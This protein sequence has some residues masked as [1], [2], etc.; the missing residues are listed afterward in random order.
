VGLLLIGSLLNEYGYNIQLLDCMDRYHPMLRSSS[1]TSIA[2]P[3][4][5]G[6]GRYYKEYIPKPDVLKA[7]PRRFG[8]YGLPLDLVI[9]ELHRYPCPD[10]VFITS[11]MTYWY[12]G[13]VKMI[14]LIR[15]VFPKAPIVL[16]GIY[17]S[18]C[19]D[20]ARGITGAD[21]VVDG[22][23]EIEALKIADELTGNHSE[24]H[25]YKAPED[26]PPPLYE[27]YPTLVSAALLTSRG[28]PYRCP[29][30]ASHLLTQGYR[31]EKPEKVISQIQRLYRE[32]G[33]R[34]FAF[35]DDALLYLK[36]EH[37]LPILKGIVN[38]S[39]PVRF[40]TPNG[41]QPREVNQETAV[42]MRKSQFE[43]LWLSYESSNEERQKQMG[44]KV[45][46]QDL[47]QAVQC[48]LNAGFEPSQLGSYVL[49]GLPGQQ[50]GEVLDSISFVYSLG[51]KVSLASFSPIPGTKSWSDAVDQGI[52]RSNADPLMTNNTYF[53]VL[54]RTV[55]YQQYLKL[56]S[57]VAEANR[58][59]K[60]G[61]KP[62]SN[63]NII[64]RMHQLNV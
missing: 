18:L 64:K 6:T 40:H 12:P 48:L 20:H 27:L 14:E 57:L 15:G 11:G 47:I 13:V 45:T 5:N 52:L 61:G 32:Q 16:G 51:I 25:R 4:D 58:I 30:C 29:F 23:G 44:F 41:L 7:V 9:N 31:R 22:E 60:R 26:F 24:I 43:T 59:L 63:R 37:I 34:H 21:R 19:P 38:L 53:P 46:N 50:I 10:A 33:V 35:Y 42:L 17:A 36:Q 55:P 28:C 49:F 8:R 54:S 62:L 39:L 3:R 56:G 1:R 2:R